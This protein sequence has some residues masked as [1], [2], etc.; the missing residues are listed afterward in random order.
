MMAKCPCCGIHLNYEPLKKGQIE[1]I[2]DTGGCLSS[3]CFLLGLVLVL[4]SFYGIGLILIFVS[5]VS[6]VASYATPEVNITCPNCGRTF[7]V[8]GC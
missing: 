8:P 3:V 1:N 7:K 4:L 5:L 2:K 6:W